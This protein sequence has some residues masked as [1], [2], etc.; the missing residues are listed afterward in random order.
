[1]RPNPAVRIFCGEQRE[2][3]GKRRLPHSIGCVVAL[4]STEEST[5]LRS[6]HRSPHDEQPRQRVGLRV[7]AIEVLGLRPP[8]SIGTGSTAEAREGAP[9]HRNHL[10][11]QHR[12]L[13]RFDL[14][15][16]RPG[17]PIAA[18]VPCNRAARG[19]SIGTQQAIPGPTKA[20]AQ[21]F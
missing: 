5:P 16:C 12:S 19:S 13:Q 9:P 4:L 7:A 2:T 1:M 6:Q 18:A 3:M 11:R 10:V 8:A 15:W 20:V 21:N 17:L 14:R